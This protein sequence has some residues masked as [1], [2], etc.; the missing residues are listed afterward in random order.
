MSNLVREIILERGPFV[1]HLKINVLPDLPKKKFI[2]VNLTLEPRQFDLYRKISSNL[3]KDLQQVDSAGFEANKMSF[4]ARR[5]ALLQ[6]CSNPSSIVDEYLETPEKILAL[7]SILDELIGLK[8]E[9][10]IVWSFYTAS[11]EAI[12]ARYGKFNPVRYDGTVTETT[13]RREAVRLFKEDLD[14]K[15]FVGNPAAAGAGLNLQSAR[16]A[17][18][19][20]MSNQAAHY[21]Q[22]LD[23]IHRGGQERDVEYLI[24]LCAGTIEVSEYERLIQK[25][26]A[27]Q[28]M[29]GDT[30]EPPITRELMLAE[31][32]T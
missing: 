29:L 32:L 18:Y 30:I 17:D 14:T 22:S 24:L 19:E 3:I 1:W 12:I 8:K 9:K 25:E 27:A 31:L 15:L 2:R 28:D 13:V 11:V 21:L 16:Y 20:S 4:F 5:S 23:R 6:I 10:V 26:K 7:D